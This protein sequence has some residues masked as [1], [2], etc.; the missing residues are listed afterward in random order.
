MG[1]RY[2]DEELNNLSNFPTNLILRQYCHTHILFPG[3]PLSIFDIYEK[4]GKNFFYDITKCNKRD[5]F[6][7]DKVDVRWH[8]IRKEYIP[9]TLNLPYNMQKSFVPVGERV[10]IANEFVFMIILNYLVNKEYLF[11]N[12]FVHCQESKEITEPIF[13][14]DFDEGGLVVEDTHDPTFRFQ[15]LGLTSS[16]IF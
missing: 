14:G 7:K 13:I 6:T 2:T 16:V 8:M 3:A 4:V 11:E 15:N 1:V 10:S 12:N 9:N 5:F